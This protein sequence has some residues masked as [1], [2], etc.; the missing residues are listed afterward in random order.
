MFCPETYTPY[1]D[2]DCRDLAIFYEATCELRGTTFK[3][4]LVATRKARGIYY[5]FICNTTYMT[6][7]PQNAITMVLILKPF[8]KDDDKIKAY[9]LTICKMGCCK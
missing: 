6:R 7:P 9:V 1:H 4:Y 8:C 5:R 3:P 2:V